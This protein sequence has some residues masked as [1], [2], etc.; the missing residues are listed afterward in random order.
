MR[1]LVPY[2]EEIGLS[3]KTLNNPSFVRA[4]VPKAFFKIGAV[5]CDIETNGANR[6]EAL[7]E[8]AELL[9]GKIIIVNPNGRNQRQTFLCPELEYTYS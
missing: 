6:K 3:V 9:S 7:N 5:L 8:L 2:L 1:E 4:Y